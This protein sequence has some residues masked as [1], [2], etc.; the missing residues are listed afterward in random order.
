VA[1]ITGRLLFL[2]AL[3]APVA[4]SAQPSPLPARPI[5][6]EVGLSANE[7]GG[8]L[9]MLLS[10][11]DDEAEAVER[12]LRDGLDD[13][14]W[15]RV[16]STE[17]EAAVAVSRCHRSISSRRRSRD[18]KQTTISFRYVVAAG[19]AIRGE[20][21]SIEAET[22]VS[23]TYS[24]SASR[25]SPSRGEDRDAFGRAGSE[26]ARKAREWLLPRVAVLRP[27]GP[28]AGFTHRTRFRLL[29]KGDGL[30]VTG[31]TLG[32]A[33]ER[34]GLRVG[35]RIR[36]IDREGGT[37]QMDE[38]VRTW[39]LE[40]AGTQVTLEVERDHERTTMVLSLERPTARG[41]GKAARK[42]VS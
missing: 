30:E 41:E 5:A 19:I 37:V 14:P 7:R 13:R 10:A 32:S 29:L 12:E 28:D 18:G 31:V 1:V 15:V 34:A 24:Q 40:P 39:R 42:D 11:S 6:V 9:D 22:L 23:R 33:A 3:A 20:R 27:D 26:L 21:D 35:D 25:Q 4:V 2:A 17:G 16:V 36:R 8:L 38:R